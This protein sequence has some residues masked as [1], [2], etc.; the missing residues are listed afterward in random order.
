LG[1]LALHA[2]DG[3][4]ARPLNEE[5]L[6]LIQL[7]GGAWDV[8][9]AHYYLGEALFYSHEFQDAATHF[10]ALLAARDKINDHMLMTQ[11]LTTGEE[12]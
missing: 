10:E 11:L 3:A 2:D 5:G 9:M 8:A 1:E 7:N 4:Q 6:R 12:L